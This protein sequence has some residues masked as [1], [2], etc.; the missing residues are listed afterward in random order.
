MDFRKAENRKALADQVDH[1][2]KQ[3]E[4]M[5]Q[6]RRCLL[7]RSAGSE[8][9]EHGSDEDTPLNQIAQQEETLVHHLIGG[10]PQSLVVA[11]SPDLDPTAYEQTL[12]L[13]KEAARLDLRKKLRRLVRN[14]LYGLG[15]ARIGMVHDHDMPVRELAPELDEEGEVGVG[16]LELNV[17][18]PEAWV[19]DS[20]ADTLEEVR[21]CGHCYW[22][23]EEDLKKYLPGVNP[24]D[25]QAEEKKNI[26][27]HGNETAAAISRGTQG[28]GVDQMG[29]RYWLWDIWCPREKVIVTMPV[30]GTGEYAHV[31]DWTSRP[32]GPYLFLYYRE[33]CDQAMPVAIQADLALVH[34]AINST[35]RKLIEQIR[36]QMT[37][38]GFKPGHE[39]DAARVRDAKSRKIVQ[40]RDPKAVQEFSFNGPDQSMLA[41]LPFLRDFASII[42][43]NT[44]AIAGLANQAP[45]LGQEEMVA[46]KAGVKVKAHGLDTA[47]FVREVFEAMRWY[48]YHEQITPISITKEIPGTDIRRESQFNALSAQEM[49]GGKFDA[50][51]LQIEPDSLNHKT[52]DERLNEMI[53]VWRELVLPSLQLGIM[54]DAPDMPALLDFVA[55]Y[56]NL[57]EVRSFLRTLSP[58]EKAAMMEGAGGGGEPRQSPVTTRHQVRH[59]APGGPNQRNMAMQMLQMAGSDNNGG[60]Q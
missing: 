22:V 49:T 39:D 55:R 51:A 40:M 54:Q 2:R 15:I 30:G 48:L 21:F 18:S 53:M 10:D 58:E 19:H 24:K 59:S 20:L 50:F 16:R 23:E 44:D 35:F 37:V 34:D 46:G 9:Y 7:K 33:L 6:A 13:N 32:G 3:L 57:P 26:D 1:S 60:D 36:E 11:S 8:W 17:I 43:G 52:S 38:L 14:A 31:R 25:L 41:A 4:H 5:L 42:G 28:E 47:I 12:A 56:R 27:E 29:K 45:T